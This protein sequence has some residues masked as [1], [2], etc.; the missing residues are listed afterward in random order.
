MKNKTVQKPAGTVTDFWIVPLKERKKI[1]DS[2]LVDSGQIVLEGTYKGV[3]VSVVVCGEVRLEWKG[4]TYKSA[5]QYPEDLERALRNHKFEKLG[6]YI[7]ANNWYELRV[8]KDKQSLNEVDVFNGD[9]L[10]EMDLNRMSNKEAKEFII[11]KA[12]AYIQ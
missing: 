10:V 7:G 4:Q 8:C 11:E 1:T 12:Q 2:L 9:C 5:S 6:G 3:Q